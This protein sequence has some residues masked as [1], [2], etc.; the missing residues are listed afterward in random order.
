[1]KIKQLTLLILL[2]LMAGNIFGQ[3]TLKD[4]Q[5][6]EKW[7]WCN[8]GDKI[9]NTNIRPNWIAEGDAFWYSTNT[10][11]GVEY[12]HVDLK[13]K[14]KKALFN[15]EKLAAKLSTFANK[16][17]LAKDLKLNN[18]KYTKENL[19]FEIDTFLLALD[20]KT[21]TISKREKPVKR[22]PQELV[23]PNKKRIAFIKDYNLFI[24]NADGSK[25]SQLSKGGNPTLS[26]G[27]SVSWYF[28]K[29]E[30]AKQ[31]MQ[32]EIDAY[33]SPDSKYIIC[34]KYNREHSENLYMLKTTAEEGFR[35]EVYS[36]DRAIA[37]DP[38]LT[39]VSYTVFDAETGKEIKSDLAEN[40]T[41]LEYG[42][43]WKSDTKAYTLRYERGYQKRELIEL[44]VTTGKTRV[45]I[46]ENSETYVDPGIHQYNINKETNDFFWASEKDGWNHLYRYNYE[47]GELK[48]QVTKGAFFI[49][50]ICK[51]DYK[52][53]KLYFRACGNEEGDPYYTYL[54]SINFDG[55][56]MTLLGS[57]NATHSCSV[58]P[59]N[60]YIFDNYSR[61]DLPDRFLVRRAKDGKK[62]MDIAQTD[63]EDIVKMGWKAPKMF[64]VKG[65]DDKTDIFGVMF[66]PFNMDTNKSYPVID[67]TYS[68]PHT[69]RAPKT[70]RRGLINMD[71]PMAQLGFVM[72]NVD[73]FGSAF[74]SKKF[75]DFSYK[76]LGD[77]G[78]PDHIK[79][80]KDLAKEHKYMD[81]ENVGIYGHS[82]GGYDATHALLTHPKFY[83]VGVSCA[84]NHDHRSAKAWW[85]ELFMGYPVG[86]HYDEQSNYF[87]ADKL[88]GKLLIVHGN[89][90]N[91]VNPAASMR[92]SDELIKANKDFELILL[93]GKDHG[94]AYYDKYFI[95][96]RWDFFVENLQH[97]QAP[98][99][100]KIN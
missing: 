81:T 85:P 70:F 58:S 9:Y 93:P 99:E 72:V 91:N 69:I 20:L 44:D 8:I 67:G 47:T 4:Y 68:G 60:K 37:G 21:Y 62:V 100:F 31:E 45:V 3:G 19:Q 35:A 88:E 42:F 71:V 61:V 6:A 16:E 1:M 92:M 13:K 48:N 7:L 80:I 22:T 94:T 95:R 26:Y 41:F 75:H 66:Q 90:D 24:K 33:W 11:N 2:S 89:M 54:Y 53:E 40:A 29:N 84:G 36:Y 76:N 74:R 28:I 51:V 43:Q 50:Q 55:S 18:V 10:R 87:L 32:Y 86:K 34:A 98:K 78:A 96:K 23:S 39:V 65:R 97:K 56:N 82:A 27:T 83:K 17:F 79:A 59:N 46:S 49:R 14:K 52:N 25:E 12:F 38:K 77:I 73:G 30:S 57:E 64:K 5:E 63:I 15:K